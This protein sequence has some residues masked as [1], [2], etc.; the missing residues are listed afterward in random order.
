MLYSVPWEQEPWGLRQNKTMRR[1]SININ[2]FKA[3]KSK[4]HNYTQGS[5]EGGACALAGWWVGP[6]LRWASRSGWVIL[7]VS[8]PPGFLRADQNRG[9]VLV[10]RR[11]AGVRE[12]QSRCSRGSTA[13][14]ARCTLP[15]SK[16]LSKQPWRAECFP[17]LF[18]FPQIWN[19]ERPAPEC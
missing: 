7:G 11:T 12:H 9:P 8:Q 18:L 2:Q 13:L 5:L 3:G 16:Q 17:L 14:L 19:Q 1:L 15:P 4:M 6:D 10:A